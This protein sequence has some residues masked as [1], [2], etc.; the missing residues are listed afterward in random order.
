MHG[1][2]SHPSVNWKGILSVLEPFS[3]SIRFHVGKGDR[4]RFWLDTWIGDSPL[5]SQFTNLFRCAQ[6]GEL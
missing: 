6:M 5:A 2:S 4:V 3:Q 1:G